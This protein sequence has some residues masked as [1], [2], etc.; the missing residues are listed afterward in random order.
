VSA[1]IA[2][3]N[4]E[5]LTVSFPRDDGLRRDQL[6]I[7]LAG[8][9]EV[10]IDLPLAGMIRRG[11]LVRTLTASEVSTGD[12]VVRSLEVD[13]VGRRDDLRLGADD[14]LQI[15][16]AHLPDE[17]LAPRDERSR[18]FLLRTDLSERRT[19]ILLDKLETMLELVGDYY[20]RPLRQPLQCV[21]VENLAQWDTSGFPSH[22]VA[23]IRNG[24]GTTVYSRIGRQQSAVVWSAATDAVV[25]H[26]SVH[27]YCF[28][29]FQATGPLWYAEGMAEVGR[30]W[31]PDNP[32]VNTDPA[33]L[34]FLRDSDP[35]PITQI[36]DDARVTG[37][38]WKPYAWRWAMC[39]L[40]VN[41]PNYAESWH[42]F[43][44]KLLGQYDAR[45]P[46]AVA[47]ASLAFRNAFEEH[48][49]ELSF[50]Y[51]QMLEHLNRGLRVD[52][53]AWD[54]KTAARPLDA[55]RNVKVTIAANRGWQATGIRVKPGETFE[56][57]AHGK[58]RLD[59]HTPECG[60]DGLHGGGA[61]R[62][63]GVLFSDYHLSDEIDLGA[64]VRW[65]AQH[66]GELFLRCREAMAAIADNSGEVDVTIG[67]AD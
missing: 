6:K 11:D 39:H 63:V 1:R 5:T 3:H 19:A 38:L 26:E 18:N 17:P 35:Q 15:R 54:W 29:V 48:G 66:G 45:E 55:G 34:G 25:Q 28:L 23:K 7:D 67:R 4:G 56:V 57:N 58:W 20:G 33:I 40:L 44:R 64:E 16:Y 47:Q 49:R 65:T 27:G 21:V 62:L 42:R 60:P 12:V 24:E 50:E 51:Q 8:I 52:L 22:A 14:E 36:L 10:G 30:F 31:E 13:L 61:G 59:G 2:E 32:A 46:D 9:E 41:N 43:G 37:E 53:T